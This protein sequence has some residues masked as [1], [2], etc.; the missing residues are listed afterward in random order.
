[1]YAIPHLKEN[2]VID[3][4]PQE[5][6]GNVFGFTSE[7]LKDWILESE[8]IE[9]TDKGVSITVRGKYG[10]NPAELVYSFDNNNRLRIDYI[11]NIFKIGNGIRQIGIGF[12]LPDTYNTLNWKR[13]SLWS[14]YPDDHIGRTE[15]TAKA[16]YPETMSDYLQQRTIPTHGFNRDG[17]E[18]GSNDFRSTK[19]NIITGRLSNGKGVVVTIESNGKQHF[20]AWVLPGAISFLVANYSDAG[21][22]FYLNYDSNRTRY[23]DS[24]IAEDG[25]VARWIQLNFN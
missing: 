10:E 23:L 5:R 4:I 3:Y 15:G 6:T 8:S 13:K 12:H 20:R 22:E 14:I 7:P 17:N 1:M 2:E 19:Q 16:F 18:Y 24:Y 25:D 11:L 9:Q 21:N